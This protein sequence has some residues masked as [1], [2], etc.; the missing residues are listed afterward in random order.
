M[1]VITLAQLIEAGACDEEMKTFRRAFGASVEVT[2]D[3]AVEYADTFSFKWAAT[4][5]LKEGFVHQFMDAHL[6]LHTAYRKTIDA[7]WEVYAPIVEPARATLD[8]AH[9][10]A[11]DE[12]EREHA[13]IWARYEAA[14]KEATR[15]YGRAYAALTNEA[16][17]GLA[18]RGSAQAALHRIKSD[19]L[20]TVSQASERRD[21]ELDQIWHRLQSARRQADRAFHHATREGRKAYDAVVEPAREAL[22]VDIARAFAKAYLSM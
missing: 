10:A 12:N 3:L 1:D 2:E 8:A 11:G 22:R 21:K 20:A 7:A 19:Y 6:E 9:K 15:P 13:A 5:L 18:S 16:A 4:H 14:Y 17:T